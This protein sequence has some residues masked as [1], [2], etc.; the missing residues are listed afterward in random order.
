M[1]KINRVTYIGFLSIILLSCNNNIN[2]TQL[3]GYWEIESVTFANG[4]TKSYKFNETV[5][6]IEVNENL[7]GFR[8][9]LKPGINNTYYEVGKSEPLTLKVENDSLNIYYKTS[10][11]SW[12]ETVL[13]AD[14]K[15]LK[16]ITKN[17]S[18]Y[19]YKRYKPIILDIKP[20]T[21]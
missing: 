15:Q 16:I 4:Q 13:K 6:Y 3:N 11:N 19:L 17:Q 12:K 20:N 8:K 14:K 10:F 7:V 1:L 9:K 2:T 21:K 5:D 18:V